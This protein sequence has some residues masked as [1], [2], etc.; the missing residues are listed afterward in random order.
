MKQKTK[1]V[2]YFYLDNH[3]KH[4]LKIVYFQL[5]ADLKNI[6]VVLLKNNLTV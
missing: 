4:S 5:S 2:N 3:E 6:D 1:T